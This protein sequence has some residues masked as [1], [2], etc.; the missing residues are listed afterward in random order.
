M[1]VLYSHRRLSIDNQIA[2]RADIDGLGSS[3]T[4]H[5][6]VV[7]AARSKMECVSKDR[8]VTDFL[9]V[10]K[11]DV[12]LVD[13]HTI[14]ILGNLGDIVFRD[15]L[16]A[17]RK[18]LQF[19]HIK[20]LRVYQNTRSINNGG[21]L[22]VAE[23]NLI[24]PQ[25]AVRT[26]RLKLSDLAGVKLELSV[27]AKDIFSNAQRRHAVGVV[28]YTAK[29]RVFTCEETLPPR[30]TSGTSVLGSPVYEVGSVLI[31]GRGKVVSNNYIACT[32][33]MQWRIWEAYLVP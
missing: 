1:N 24:A 17:S 5:K 23:E 2:N 4:R 9:T 20:T 8:A 28:R 7:D 10:R 27:D 14:A 11:R 21:V 29:L 16:S 30:G 6:Y 13:K 33:E 32:T 3:T 15:H 12:C 18:P 19:I 31:C 22:F 26:A 25:I